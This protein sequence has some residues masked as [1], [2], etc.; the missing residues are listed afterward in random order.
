MTTWMQYAA[1]G[2]AA[3]VAL[4]PVL[5]L[6]SVRRRYG[7]DRTQVSRGHLVGLVLMPWRLRHDRRAALAAQ[8]DAQAGYEAAVT[9]FRAAVGESAQ[10]RAELA[11]L[12][13]LAESG[14][15]DRAVAAKVDAAPD[16]DAPIARLYLDLA[17][18]GDD[19][20][21][22]QAVIRT[23]RQ[24][25]SDLE[26]LLPEP[27]AAPVPVPGLPRRARAEAERWHAAR[28]AERGELQRLAATVSTTGLV[29]PQKKQ[30]PAEAVAV[31]S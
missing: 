31:A 10:Y 4:W 14:R 7:K 1:G 5:G 26:M 23:V 3:L 24:G 19:E 30:V 21:R 18:V 28:A 9:H 12:L 2:A 15:T 29:P 11:E 16:P 8:A 20:P 17:L 22:R 6:V 27:P 13:A 25:L